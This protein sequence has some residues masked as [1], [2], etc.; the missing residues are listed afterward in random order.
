MGERC[1]TEPTVEEL[2]AEHERA[3]QARIDEY[4]CSFNSRQLAAKL[5]DTE[6]ELGG[7]TEE[8]L[9]TGVHADVA[10]AH[11]EIERLTRALRLSEAR[12]GGAARYVDQADARS[13]MLE[14]AMVAYEGIAD[15]CDRYRI[16]W[17]SARRR[18]A[19]ETNLGMEAVE[20]LQAEV[21]RLR[22]QLDLRESTLGA[23][24]PTESS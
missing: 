21:T 16:A 12:I 5:V 17:L 14:N 13:Q 15:E 8:G 11:C 2:E 19:E 24:E 3:R 4:D 9:C 20:H 10:E 18:A 23:S 1:G 7:V 22:A 6:D